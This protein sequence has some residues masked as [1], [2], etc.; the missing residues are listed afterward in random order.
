[1]HEVKGTKEVLNWVST[2][3]KKDYLG[4]DSPIQLSFSSTK[5]FDDSAD[6]SAAGVNRTLW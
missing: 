4:N 1:M 6:V 5:E 2:T 3:K